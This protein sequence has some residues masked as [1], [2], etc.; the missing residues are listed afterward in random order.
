MD[1]VRKANWASVR[2]S[3]PKNERRRTL[4]DFICGRL[5]PEDGLLVAY[6]KQDG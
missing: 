2:V 3:S 5:H 4:V 1:R 6:G